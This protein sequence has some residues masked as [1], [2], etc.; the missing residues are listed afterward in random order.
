MTVGDG[1]PAVR[2]AGCRKMPSQIARGPVVQAGQPRRSR[3]NRELRV[4]ISMEAAVRALTRARASSLQS[5]RLPAARVPEGEHLDT[6][7]VIDDAEVSV[8]ADA[9]EENAAAGRHVPG[10]LA[11]EIGRVLE[12]V[13]PLRKL[14]VECARRLLA[15]LEPP[16]SRSLNLARGPARELDDGN[17]TLLWRRRS[18]RNARAST[19]SRRSHS[20][21]RR[22]SSS[23]SSSVTSNPRM[24]SRAASR[25][26]GPRGGRPPKRGWSSRSHCSHSSTCCRR[27]PTAPAPGAPPPSPSRGAQ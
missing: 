20:A 15:G 2:P 13:D 17:Q 19:T 11:D 25:G 22:R 12:M 6:F 16:L 18:S 4:A 9:L 7:S 26:A 14:L 8:V 1:A 24:S 21:S 23:R 10:V 5:R 3:A 27:R